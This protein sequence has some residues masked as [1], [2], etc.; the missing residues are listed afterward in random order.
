MTEIIDIHAHLGDILY[1][2]GGQL[3]EKTGVTRQNRVD[4]MGFMEHLNAWE[5]RV[6]GRVYGLLP[7]GVQKKIEARID[8]ENIYRNFTATRENLRRE[9]DRYGISHCALLPVY[10]YVTF[11]DLWSAAQKD[12]ALI[13]FTGADFA[14]LSGIEE[15][16][17]QDVAAG[18]KGLKLH[19]ILQ[20]AKMDEAETI[21]VVE[22]FAPYDLPILLHT[23]YSNY[24][25]T[26]PEAHLQNTDYG[27]IEHIVALI[28]AF[29]QVKFI[30]GH[31][32]LS[33]V[34]DLMPLLEGFKNVWVDVSFQ[35][36]PAIKQL[37]QTFGADKVMYASDWPWGSIG[38]SI[39]TV[40]KA[41]RGDAGLRRQLFYEN[42]A[43]LLKIG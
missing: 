6:V 26:P 16:F 19:P 41:C 25:L 36:T 11:Q 34:W 27:D 12:S 9:L 4:F 18:A 21:R 39:K 38:P 22:A 14:D 15:K 30:A 29:P 35:A 20:R 23:G 3:I 13:P 2:N 24:Y 42:A 40:E 8:Q 37:I 17:A 1:P 33:S 32:G 7:G 5:S 28:K 10:P 31:A 43:E